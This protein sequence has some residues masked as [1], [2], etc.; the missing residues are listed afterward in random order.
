[1][2]TE[3]EKTIK[4]RCGREFSPLYQGG[5]RKSRV[6]LSCLAAKAREKVKK[7]KKKKDKEAKEKLKTHSEW[8]QDLQKV[9]NKFIR[10]RDIDKPCISCGS[11][12]I[13]KY[14]AG[15][16]FSVGAYPNLRF[17]EDNVHGQCVHCN[18]HKHG[19]INEYSLSL[20][21][22]IG[23]ER[24]ENLLA[25]REKPLKLSIE[26]IKEKIKYYKRKIKEL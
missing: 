11:R 20:P 2:V 14:D 17:N 16:Y 26:E 8:L 15:H 25:E 1:M 12:L 4:C 19:N 10:I 22:R 5:I 3:G 23:I 21:L 7:D 6:C 18:Q 9:F 13:G 24:F